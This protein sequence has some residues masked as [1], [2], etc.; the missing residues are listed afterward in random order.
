M[1]ALSLISTLASLIILILLL[2]MYMYLPAFDQTPSES[3]GFNFR[4]VLLLLLLLPLVSFVCSLLLSL[5]LFRMKGMNRRI[6][7]DYPYTEIC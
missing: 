4:I 2:G 1:R 3:H 6:G 5:K 7:L